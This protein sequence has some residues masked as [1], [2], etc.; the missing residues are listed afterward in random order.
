MGWKETL[1]AAQAAIKTGDLDGGENLIRQAELEKRADGLTEV[2][3][4][5]VDP[6]ARLPFATEAVE[7][8]AEP[9][10][11]IA[12]KSWYTRKYGDD[13]AAMDQVMAELYGPSHKH[14]S[15]AKTADFVR[16]IRSGY[17]D[18]KLHRAVVYSPT[19]V[20]QAL[21]DGLSVGELKA[22]QVESQDTLGGYL[23]PE[24]VR[25]QIVQ[26]LVGMTAMRKVA[27]QMN[28][29]RDRVTMP[30]GTG[31]DDRYTGAVRAA[32]VDESPT[33]HSRTPTPP[34]DRSQSP[35]MS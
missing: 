8:A 31:G 18:P 26:R 19:Q 17:F 24:D 21:A 16:Y 25:D 5:T 10:E 13:G 28:T 9:T 12:V 7:S 2:K 15:W 29:T 11:S 32:W 22:T 14:L 1:E 3:T 23:V 6:A 33:G 4:A 30:V 35:C 27:G 34:L 20:A